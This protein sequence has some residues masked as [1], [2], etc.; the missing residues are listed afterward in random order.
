MDVL[1]PSTTNTAR[2]VDETAQVI[3]SEFL[4]FLREFEDDG[5]IVYRNTI[6][7]MKSDELMTLYVNY[8]HLVEFSETVA[9]AIKDEF[10]TASFKRIVSAG[11]TVPY[12]GTLF[13]LYFTCRDPDSI[14]S[15]IKWA[16]AASSA[17]VMAETPFDYA[18]RAM[19]GSTRMMLGAGL[20]YVPFATTMLVMYD[21]FVIKMVTGGAAWDR[22]PVASP[23]SAASRASAASAASPAPASPA[24][25]VETD[26]DA[27]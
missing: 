20:L 23:A 22:G 16:A 11:S 15:Q 25:L 1:D 3:E 18:K 13:G 21:K 2:I 6:D 26:Y 9:K 8:E 19:L 5:E 10:Y 14:G 4:K 7:Q 24:V 12:A 17:A 27:I